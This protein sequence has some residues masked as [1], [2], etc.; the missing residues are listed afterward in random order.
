MRTVFVNFPKSSEAIARRWMN[1]HTTQVGEDEWHGYTFDLRRPGFKQHA[2]YCHLDDDY[3]DWDSDTW[4]AL[5]SAIP[6]LSAY[7]QADVSGRIAGEKEVRNLVLGLLATVPGSV[8]DDDMTTHQWTLKE[9]KNGTLV[10]GHRF[11]DQEG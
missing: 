9:I 1:R 7:I 5:K 10:E 8:A 3:S 2:L 4:T 11:F 6:G